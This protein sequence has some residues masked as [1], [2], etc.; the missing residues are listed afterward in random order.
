MGVV[1]GW[2]LQLWRSKDSWYRLGWEHYEGK[3]QLIN[4][5]MLEMVLQV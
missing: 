4:V 5:C 1:C 2:E 3:I